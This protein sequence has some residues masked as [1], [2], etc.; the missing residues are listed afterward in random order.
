[1]GNMSSLRILDYRAIIEMM[2]HLG[3]GERWIGWISNILHSAS[4]S[5]ILNGVPGKQIICKR[6]VRQGNPLSPLL[7][8]ATAELL[9]IVINHAWQE[10]LLSLPIEESYG[11]DYPIIQYADDTIIIMPADATQI[12]NLKTLLQKFSRSTGL[13]INFH[14][15]SMVPINITTDRCDEL[16][17]I[18]GCKREAM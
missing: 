7:F 6:G 3:F 12:E 16:A 13:R 11:Q 5:V 1:M 15:S 8:V 9:Q 18:L 10:N 4:T 17:A 2:K 14:K